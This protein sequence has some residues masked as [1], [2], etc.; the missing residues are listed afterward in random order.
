M[1]HVEKIFITFLIILIDANL[2]IISAPTYIRETIADI[3]T[4][5]SLL[6]PFIIIKAAININKTANNEIKKRFQ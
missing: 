6:V 5:L 2:F 1:T 3:T 4:I